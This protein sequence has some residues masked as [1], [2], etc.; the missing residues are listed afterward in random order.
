MSEQGLTDEERQA[1]Q[2]ARAN[3]PTHQLGDQD[4]DAM[5]AEEDDRQPKDA[6]I[7]RE[8]AS[9]VDVLDDEDL[10]IPT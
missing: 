2:Q 3:P 4:R 10:S 9:V 8:D 6:S 5:S 1:L 7:V